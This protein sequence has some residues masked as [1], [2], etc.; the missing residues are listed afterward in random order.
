MT[1]I[2][3][4]KSFRYTW[5][6]LRHTYI[7]DLE[8]EIDILQVEISPS[9]ESRLLNPPYP[10]TSFFE[11]EID[12]IQKNGKTVSS[13]RNI[14]PVEISRK[15]GLN[16]LKSFLRSGSS[17]VTR[18]FQS[19]D[20]ETETRWLYT[21]DLFLIS[22][23]S[24]DRHD[25]SMLL[26]LIIQKLN[27]IALSI[28][29][30]RRIRSEFENQ[31]KYR[32]AMSDMFSEGVDGAFRD[33]PV[34]RQHGDMTGSDIDVSAALMSVEM[35]DLMAECAS[36]QPGSTE[37]VPAGISKKA[38]PGEEAPAGCSAEKPGSIESVPAGISSEV[39]PDEEAPAESADA[40]P[41]PAEQIGKESDPFA[42]IV[43]KR[44]FTEAVFEHAATA[45]GTVT[46][47]S[48]IADTSV[49]GIQAE[50]IPEENAPIKDDPVTTSCSSCGAGISGTKKFCGSCGA[51]VSP[52]T[53]AER[54][55]AAILS[56]S[57][58]GAGISG[59]KKF[60][61]SCGAAVSHVPAAERA[62][63]S[64]GITAHG[65]NDTPRSAR[66]AGEPVVNLK[67]IEELD[68]LSWLTD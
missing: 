25:L 39:T 42:N 33:V 51:A 67:S 8:S 34:Y 24:G 53:P 9:K 48:S 55:P 43:I 28:Q 59:A 60:C 50:C 35:Q 65:S 32:A 52:D 5:E 30:G 31:Q 47:P 29:S 56:C 23:S 44:T 41:A 11:I 13:F 62:P 64:S 37:S 63:V 7:V 16:F 3:E 54:P 4:H 22:L 15:P 26:S 49:K 66:S 46:E 38:A 20:G 10:R 12:Q 14:C 21:D 36:D 18:R 6:L 58:C 19:Q 61:G 27:M 57:S 40:G 2:V 68:D 1:H 17:R 45:E